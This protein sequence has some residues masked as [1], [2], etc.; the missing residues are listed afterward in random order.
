[1]VRIGGLGII[2]RV[3]SVTSIRCAIVIT[4]VA[5]C[6]IIGND[7]VRP[8][9]HIIIIV[10]RE[11]GWLPIW[12]CGMAHRTIRRQVERHVIGVSRLVEIGCMATA[13]GIW[14]IG[15]IAVVTRITIVGYRYMRTCKRVDRIMV[16]SRRHPGC[17]RV[18]RGTIG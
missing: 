16:E 3:A 6:A 15:I 17:F 12:R 4:I 14:R 7:G 8:V 9:Q 18:T 1:M 11:R 10:N 2:C 13:A 5:S